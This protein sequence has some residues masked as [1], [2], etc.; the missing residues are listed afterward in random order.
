MNTNRNLNPFIK[1]QNKNNQLH[2]YS[3]EKEKTSNRNIRNFQSTKFNNLKLKPHSLSKERK[4]RITLNTNFKYAKAIQQK[5]FNIKRN[6]SANNRIIGH[7]KIKHNFLSNKENIKKDNEDEFN[8]NYNEE[9]ENL[10]FDIHTSY[11][12]TTKNPFNFYNTD[13]QFR[14]SKNI[15]KKNNKKI[16][17]DIKEEN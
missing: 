3:N 6:I 11:N 13:I 9:N 16:N 17:F 2:T 14:S 1:R 8:I 12:L 10:L 5:T 7:N 15:L 4:K